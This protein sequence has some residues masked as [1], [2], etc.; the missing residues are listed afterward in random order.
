MQSVILSLISIGERGGGRIYLFYIRIAW[1][2]AV[3]PVGI[4]L[5]KQSPI[6][7][8]GK[9]ESIFLEKTIKLSYDTFKASL[10]SID[11]KD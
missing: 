11:K 10:K 7:L 3:W 6:I 5:D 1:N 8:V 4:F 2:H 9:E